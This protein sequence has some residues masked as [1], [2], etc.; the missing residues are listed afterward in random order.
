MKKRIELAEKSFECLIWDGL[1]TTNIRMLDHGICSGLMLL[2]YSSFTYRIYCALKPETVSTDPVTAKIKNKFIS[3]HIPTNVKPSIIWWWACFLWATAATALHNI[4]QMPS[5]W[6]G[7]DD[8]LGPLDIKEDPLSYL[9]VLV[10]ILQEW[11]RY[12]VY[13]D[14][15]LTGTLPI[16]GVDVKA[17]F[18][19]DILDLDFQ[20]DNKKKKV[21]KAL[22]TALLKWDKIVVFN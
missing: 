9:G 19:G 6:P 14:S 15:I 8:S 1:P 18:D 20:N 16:Q 4:Q 10:D 17:N 11:D 7:C 21:M 13:K 5:P 2:L 3:G 22:D 12:T